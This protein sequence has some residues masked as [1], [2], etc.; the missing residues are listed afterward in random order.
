MGFFPHGQQ[1]FL[2]NKS[3]L[4]NLARSMIFLWAPFSLRTDLEKQI[5]PVACQPQMWAVAP[6]DL[7]RTGSVPSLL[8]KHSPS[9]MLTVSESAGILT[10][11][12]APTA[13]QKLFTLPF[14]NLKRLAAQMLIVFETVITSTT[15]NMIRGL[16]CTR[17]SSKLL[18]WTNYPTR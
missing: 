5:A 13:L 6:P 8:G 4:F 17:Y 14:P 15:A 11:Y 7:V 18:M 9:L 1:L 2:L 3:V 12:T 10:I 16:S